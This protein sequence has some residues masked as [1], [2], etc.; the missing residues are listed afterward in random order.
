VW[1]PGTEVVEEKLQEFLRDN[2]MRKFVPIFADA[3]FEM[4]DYGNI[5]KDVSAHRMTGR[6]SCDRR[7]VVRIIGL[8]A[9]LEETGD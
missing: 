8:H 4:G 9:A 3:F 2:G 1:L 7:C 6:F 5:L